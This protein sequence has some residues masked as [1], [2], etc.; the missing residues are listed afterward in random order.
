MTEIN[1]EIENMIAEMR[2]IGQLP[3]PD[4]IDNDGDYSPENCRWVTAKDNSRNKRTNRLLAINGKTKT[5]SEWCEVY[6]VS[7]YTVYWWIRELCLEYG[8]MSPYY[9]YSK[10]GG[11][12]FCPNAQD[13]QL[14]YIYRYHPDLWRKMLELQKEP[15]IVRPG[16]FKIDEG[17]YEINARFELEGEQ[18]NLFE[19][20][21]MLNE[22]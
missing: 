18:L 15:N 7:P 9:Q 12:F 8:L 5:V 17:L 4:R 22:H 11:C 21:E 20:M 19:E 6:D 14:R 16:K 1:Q 13:E 3:A 10:R 2:V